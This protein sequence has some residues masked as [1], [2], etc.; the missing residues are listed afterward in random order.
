MNSLLFSVLGWPF[1]MAL[2]NILENKQDVTLVMASLVEENEHRRLKDSDRR[3][4]V[5]TIYSV[6]IINKI[7]S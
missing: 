1:V 4:L 7:H 2:N 6:S 3:L 5:V